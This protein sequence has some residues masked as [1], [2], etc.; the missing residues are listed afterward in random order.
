MN[1]MIT[2]NTNLIELCDTLKKNEKHTPHIDLNEI[3]INILQGLYLLPLNENSK[4]N[5]ESHKII[6]KQ[7]KNLFN[8]LTASALEKSMVFR[9]LNSF[10]FTKA[11]NSGS[12]L[13]KL[14]KSYPS[15][16]RFLR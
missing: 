14:S 5:I 9:R 15:K 2:F 6:T 4:Q 10:I 13:H 8:N 16:C 3:Q 7:N 1:E 12:V 11:D